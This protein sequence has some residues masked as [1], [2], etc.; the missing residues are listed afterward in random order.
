MQL[1]TFHL[2]SLGKDVSRSQAM[3]LS[4]SVVRPLNDDGVAPQRNGE[5]G[6]LLVGDFVKGSKFPCYDN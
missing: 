1:I 6:I 2:F 4:L 5:E 3:E